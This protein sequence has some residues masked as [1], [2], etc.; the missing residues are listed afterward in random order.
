MTDPTRN[1]KQGVSVSSVAAVGSL[2]IVALTLLGTMIEGTNKF[3]DVN[4]R[5]D[6]ATNAI[7]EM[8]SDARAD[9]LASRTQTLEDRTLQM[10]ADIQGMRSQYRDIQN[11]M[12]QVSTDIATIKAQLNYALGQDA[13]GAPRPAMPRK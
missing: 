9:N 2:V 3:D 1:L 5:L 4:S 8:R 12:G 13:A 6:N 11:V 10:Q 7:T